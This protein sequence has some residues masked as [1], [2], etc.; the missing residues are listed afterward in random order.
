[1]A[2][3]ASR[4]SI[5]AASA[6][7]RS[8][9]GLAAGKDA[10]PAVLEFCVKA[11]A[12]TWPLKI[13]RELLEDEEY[14]DELIDQLERFDTEYAR[15]VEPKLQVIMALEEMVHEDVRE[16]HGLHGRRVRRGL[17]A[18]AVQLEGALQVA[19]EA[20]LLVGSARALCTRCRTLF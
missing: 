10:V 4:R 18:D 20:R 12:L 17:R 15:N 11:E 8:S 5:S 19:P 9:E 2:N 1:M 7:A 6:C 16:P 14:R 3:A 13:L